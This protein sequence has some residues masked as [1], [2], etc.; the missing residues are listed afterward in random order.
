MN[1]LICERALRII[2]LYNINPT[3]IIRTGIIKINDFSVPVCNN[4]VVWVGEEA[5][6][7]AIII[8]VGVAVGAPGA[9]QQLLYDGLA[10]QAVWKSEEV[11]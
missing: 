9:V 7:F 1:Q 5:E 2:L 10:L 3:N 11:Q 6:A 8:S 4:L